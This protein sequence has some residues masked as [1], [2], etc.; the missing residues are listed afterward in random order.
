MQI[1]IVGRAYF[2]ERVFAFA[3][4]K[5]IHELC[6]RFVCSGPCGLG[7]GRFGAVRPVQ[8]VRSGSGY[9]GGA[10]AAQV[11]ILRRKL[12]NASG[13]LV[14]VVKLAGFDVLKYHRPRKGSEREEAVARLEQQMK[15]A[16]Q[17]LEFEL[18]AALRDQIIE[19]RG[20]K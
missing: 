11:V 14:V 15:E 17:R 7:S 12:Y 6:L 8:G 20:R 13:N 5:A 9:T 2:T 4:H 1:G 16:A 18:A 3:V 10:G 19:L